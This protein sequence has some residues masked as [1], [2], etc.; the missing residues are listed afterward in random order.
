M[1]KVI[2]VV[3]THGDDAYLSL[4]QHMVDWIKEGKTVIILTV[5]SGTRKR[6]RD[7]QNYADA[8]GANW[9]G[10]GWDEFNA[11]RDDYSKEPFDPLPGA[12]GLIYEPTDVSLLLALGI[13]HPD[14][15]AVTSWVQDSYAHEITY[16]T[17]IPYVS[18]HKYQEDV[19]QLMLGK[20]VF[21]YKKPKFTKGSEKFWKCFKDQAKY[22]FMNPPECYK[23]IPEIL[24]RD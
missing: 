10:L 6:A 8:I 3:E 18:K 22:F 14:H 4:H 16:F 9:V 2:V 13:F 1:N 15:K 19:N 5:F 24:L 12:L 11:N 7:S 23:D 21:S 20:R 17:D